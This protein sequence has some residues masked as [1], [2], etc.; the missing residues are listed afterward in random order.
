MS[1][2]KKS[3]K[4]KGLPFSRRH[5]VLLAGMCFLLT[6]AMTMAY[7]AGQE[8]AQNQK[9]ARTQTYAKTY[10]IPEEKPFPVIESAPANPVALAPPVPPPGALPAWQRNA[11]PMPPG[12]AGKIKI[13]LI[14]DDMGVD[15]RRSMAALG[16][17]APL[18]MAFLA[19]GQGAGTMAVRAREAGH[20]IMVHVGMQAE[21]P[22]VDPGPLALL[23]GMKQAQIDG[24]LDKNFD[25]L[26]GYV[27]FN[28]HMGSLLTQDLSAMELVMAH[29]ARRG[30]LF[31]DSRTSEQSVAAAVARGYGLPVA[32]RDVFL[33]HDE[34]L[35]GVQTALAQLED[36]ARRRG[37]AV[38]IGHPKDNTLHAL[39]IWIP[40]L[41]EKGIALVPV[42]AVITAP[43]SRPSAD[44]AGRA[45]AD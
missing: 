7:R 23:S 29:A 28:N 45:G 41:A 37:Y 11:Q 10:E 5:A 9:P 4:R 25:A 24:M 30:L 20:E 18:T 6:S 14:I 43:G 13:A 8:A 16:L 40:T 39:Q 35:A 32:V 19:Y 1:P 17:P 42:S 27:G 31:V 33:D 36:V 44:T 15:R 21:S 34:S 22:T 3:N 38:G 2:R 12:A 26:S